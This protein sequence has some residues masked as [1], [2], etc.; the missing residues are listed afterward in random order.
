MDKFQTLK[1]SVVGLSFYCKLTAVCPN[2]V[3][4]SAT[5]H[6]SFTLS[7]G[8]GV[9]GE[10]SV[11]LQGEVAVMERTPLANGLRSTTEKREN[12]DQTEGRSV[13]R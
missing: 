4:L 7:V 2:S 11:D 1:D 12:W 3:A 5:A 8:M 6:L 10:G 13:L 9:I